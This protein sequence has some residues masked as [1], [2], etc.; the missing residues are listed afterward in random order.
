[1]KA[2]FGWAIALSTRCRRLISMDTSV[3]PA[4]FSRRGRAVEAPHVTAVQLAQEVGDISRD[5]ID[6]G[7]EALEGLTVR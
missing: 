1:M 6:S 2:M 5:Q 7:G 3:A 4:V